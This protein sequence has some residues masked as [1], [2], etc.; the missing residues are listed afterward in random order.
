MMVSLHDLD[1]RPWSEDRVLPRVLLKAGACL[2]VAGKNSQ[3]REGNPRDSIS[4]SLIPI[5]HMLF[6]NFCWCMSM[7]YN[8]YNLSVDWYSWT[9]KCVLKK[10]F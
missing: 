3:E 5:F 9:Q 1:A 2:W 4:H 10:S 8:V 6:L 7:F